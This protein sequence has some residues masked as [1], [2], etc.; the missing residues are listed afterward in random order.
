MVFG[1]VLYR[2]GVFFF[3]RYLWISVRF[4]IDTVDARYIHDFAALADLGSVLEP[5]LGP[6]ANE[7]RGVCISGLPS[8]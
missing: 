6:K 8:M 5:C 4:N 1:S 3:S 7:E 2:Y